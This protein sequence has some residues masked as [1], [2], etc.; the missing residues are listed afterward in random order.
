MEPTVFAKWLDT[1]FSGFDYSILSFYHKTAEV[2]GF[3][4]TPMA[5]ILSFIGELG[6]FGLVIG[7][8]LMLF[9][10]TRKAGFCMLIAVGIGAVFTN[11]TIK[12][13]V[14]RARPFQSGNV[15]FS[16]WWSY[17][18]A[19][20]VS[21]H[22]F[23]SGHVTAAAAAM[24]GL[25]ISVKPKWL[26]APASVYV[27]AMMAARNYLMVHYPTDV[28]AGLFVGALAGT[29]SFFAVCGIVKLIK[30]HEDKS[31]FAFL[32]NSDIRNIFKS[33][34]EKLK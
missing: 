3:F 22:S 14:M 1:A 9:K 6:A 5:E 4:F 19:H 8:I 31:L 25:C 26:I 21:E 27:I 28:V 17:V 2:A 34:G 30:K 24:T 20:T 7:I 32:I 33:K 29:A 12:E 15:D 10:K 16:A 13:L 23:P 18:G 11:L